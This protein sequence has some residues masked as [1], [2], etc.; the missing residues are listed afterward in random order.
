[1]VT[2]LE[3]LKDCMPTLGV[4]KDWLEMIGFVRD[5]PLN[6]FVSRLLE[7]VDLRRGSAT[8]F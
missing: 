3:V 7:L 2:S 8:R 6:P 5:V 4:A 1:M